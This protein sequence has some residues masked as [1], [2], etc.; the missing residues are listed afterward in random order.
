M[1]LVRLICC[2]V[3]LGRYVAGNRAA[4]IGG[5]ATAFGQIATLYRYADSQIV[6]DQITSSSDP[7]TWALSFLIGPY[8]FP[9]NSGSTIPT[10][11]LAITP[12]ANVDGTITV[13]ITRDQLTTILT[14]VEYPVALW[15]TDAGSEKPLATGTLGISTV[16]TPQ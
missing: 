7:S 9:T 6:L 4:K 13:L 5:M 10:A 15:R 14:A 16:P 2:G 1:E 11:T 12:T 3:E 8:P